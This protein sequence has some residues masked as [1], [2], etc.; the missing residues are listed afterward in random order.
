MLITFEGG[1]C[2]GKDSQI[3]LL[4]NRLREENPDYKILHHLQEPGSTLKA[5][6][7]RMLVKNRHDTDFVFPGDFIST[8]DFSKYREHFENEEIPVV[9]KKHLIES[10]KQM[11]EGMK[12]ETI[13]FLLRNSFTKDSKLEGII[14]ELNSDEMK[15]KLAKLHQT[16]TP[17]DILLKDYF[18]KEVLFPEAQ[19]HIYFAT[20]N[21]LYHGIIIPNHRN[22]DFVILN[23]SL[24][25]TP[26]YQGWAQNPKLLEKIRTLN[27]E[28]V[29]GVTPDISFLIDIP[30]EEIAK[31]KF[32]R[33]GSE[34]FSSVTKDFFDE[35]DVSFHEKIRQGYLAE[36]N[37]YSSLPESSPQKD[38]IKVID[39]VG[40]PEEVRDRIWEVLKY[41]QR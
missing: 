31:R 7:L 13:T 29:E 38:R 39:G 33:K 41:T 14:A 34:K 32:C 17:A 16:T 5:E 1:E 18:S 11:P 10:L 2:A 8:L 15:E 22:Y 27:L 37:Y 36:A 19:M 35:K 21:M 24:D 12:Y 40:T 23:R 25:S 3:E 4:A 28:A 9:A 6:V 30:V 20:R 26:V